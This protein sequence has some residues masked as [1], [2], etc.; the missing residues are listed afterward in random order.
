MTEDDVAAAARDLGVTL[1]ASPLAGSMSA[2]CVHAVTRADGTRAVLKVTAA[3][4]GRARQAAEREL[5]V[6]LHLRGRLGVRTPELLGHRLSTHRVAV[7]LSEHPAPWPATRWSHQRWLGLADEL[8][9]LHQTP[10][11][12]GPGWRRPSWLEAT[13]VSPDVSAAVAFWSWP[14]EP[15]LLAPVLADVESLRDA[16]GA[17]AD[18]FLHGDCHTDNLLVEGD[19]LVWTDWQ[20]AG[21]GNPAVELVFCSVRATPA[22]VALPQE[23][24]VRRYAA[25]RDLDP[26]VVR[27]ACLAAELA[28]FL[29]TWPEYASFNTPAGVTRVH[30]R[31]VALARAWGER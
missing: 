8:A 7:L 26:G 25:A 9:R 28:T 29:F 21:V 1:T 22:G 4:E 6:Y 11:P 24:M 23:A 14:G 3:S 16:V 30:D 18:C 5:S 17:V 20:G 13:L 31:V 12:A 2:S 19:Q 15:A 10:V 27:R